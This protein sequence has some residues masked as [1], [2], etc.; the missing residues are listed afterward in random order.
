M[1]THQ[2]VDYFM[3]IHWIRVRTHHRTVRDAWI[4]IHYLE[5]SYAVLIPSIWPVLCN[6]DWLYI[7]QI[8]FLAVFR[9]WSVLLLWFTHPNR[10]QSMFSPLIHFYCH[11][12]KAQYRLTVLLSQTPA[13]RTVNIHHRVP[14]LKIDEWYVIICIYVHLEPLT[15]ISR[16]VLILFHSVMRY[17]RIWFWPVP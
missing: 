14:P 13:S 5:I 7:H 9:H 12:R 2:Y 1:N 8:F 4:S 16:C 10:C 17:M 11:Y 15:C 3:I 6:Y